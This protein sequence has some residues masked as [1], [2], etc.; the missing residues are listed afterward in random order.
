MENQGFVALNF[1]SSDST[2]ISKL[3]HDKPHQNLQESLPWS[4]NDDSGGLN[5]F[6]ELVS[7]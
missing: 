1:F 7:P 5:P 3:L 6:L 2:S 4:S